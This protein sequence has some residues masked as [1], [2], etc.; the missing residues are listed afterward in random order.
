M[1]DA[2]FPLTAEPFDRAVLRLVRA[3]SDLTLRQAAV[4]LVTA[5]AEDPPT[6]RGLASD[7]NVSKPVITR[8]LDKLGGQDLIRR[9]TDPTD[10]RS[11]LITVTPAGRAAA[12]SLWRA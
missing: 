6:V 12:E 5:T 4:L 7:L 9:R 10:R 1:P 3:G 2:T 8:A 11:V